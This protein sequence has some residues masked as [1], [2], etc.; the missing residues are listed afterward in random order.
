MRLVAGPARC[1]GAWGGLWAVGWASARAQC[2]SAPGLRLRTSLCSGQAGRSA[3]GA[4]TRQ[5]QRW[6]A[7]PAGRWSIGAASELRAGLVSPGAW[8]RPRLGSACASP[9]WRG[10][11]VSGWGRPPRLALQCRTA[12]APQCAQAEAKQG[13]RVG[14]LGVVRG[15]WRATARNYG[16]RLELSKCIEH[17]AGGD[18]KRS[19]EH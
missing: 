12:R 9:D 11:R 8:N 19:D 5:R 15:Y 2:G 10:R 13:R 14:S 16:S 6:S 1:A 4:P 17:I 3:L 18:S 7:T